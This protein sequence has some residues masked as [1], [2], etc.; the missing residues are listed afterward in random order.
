M[1]KAFPAD[2]I[3]CF[4]P[5][6]IS[7]F[8][9]DHLS[10]LYNECIMAAT[11]LGFDKPSAT[12]NGFD[13]GMYTLH[14]GPGRKKLTIPG[15]ILMKIPSINELIIEK[16][17]VEDEPV[18]LEAYDPEAFATVL[19]LVRD[20]YD[21]F[22]T[23][24]T[25]QQLIKAYIVA[26]DLNLEHIQNFLI[27]QIKVFHGSQ[28]VQLQ[29]FELLYAAQLTV[30]CKLHAFLLHKMAH[31]FHRG[32][33]RSIESKCGMSLNIEH[34]KDMERL[35]K[36]D[37][38][39]L[40]Y[41][42]TLLST[43]SQCVLCQDACIFHQHA[44]TSKCT[45]IDINGN[46]MPEISY[47][48]AAHLETSARNHTFRFTVKSP[49]PSGK[50]DMAW[51][52]RAAISGTA[53]SDA[54]AIEY[55]GTEYDHARST[56]FTRIDQWLD[57]TTQSMDDGRVVQSSAANKS[58]V[59]SMALVD[60]KLENQNGTAI[61][62]TDSSIV[63]IATPETSAQSDEGS[64]PRNT[65]ESAPARSLISQEVLA[66]SVAST[67]EAPTL[68][69][70]E[71]LKFA[72]GKLLLETLRDRDYFD[73]GDGFAELG[74]LLR[75]FDAGNVD[76]MKDDDVRD[77][78]E[79][80]SV[81]ASQGLDLPAGRDEEDTYSEDS[82]TTDFCGDTK[83]GEPL[84]RLQKTLEFVEKILGNELWQSVESLNDPV[85]ALTEV[86]RVLQENDGQLTEV[87]IAA[88]GEILEPAFGENPSN[89]LLA[90][91]LKEKIRPRLAMISHGPPSSFSSDFPHLRH[92]PCSNTGRDTNESNDHTAKREEHKGLQSGSGSGDDGMILN[93][94]AEE[95]RCY[96]KDLG[97]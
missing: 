64:S 36:I 38:I 34:I 41:Q 56:P 59:V 57:A 93:E 35:N 82:Q 40:T 81:G 60:K 1:Q 21:G 16:T 25:S 58:E 50:A 94:V 72:A 51:D 44:F 30:D 90:Q 52:L 15:Y 18:A 83:V 65:P 13:T 22:K 85:G 68:P 9:S 47:I 11:N 61:Q 10:L 46:G 37:L 12:F 17:L 97:I 76:T 24:Q 88:L 45:S 4:R 63:N 39:Q 62:S 8:R 19:A 49:P 95:I 2:F 43:Q 6:R 55:L 26:Y 28:L 20:G 89:T 77:D 53:N 69:K 74:D 84:F 54:N 3:T 7:Y 75:D 23:P 80:L 78:R 29:D 27:N 33:H 66:D 5:L 96:K 71:M 79:G 73:E 70:A 91:A 42:V 86:M 67:Q 48:P 92:C 87:C 31:E 14:V 32:L